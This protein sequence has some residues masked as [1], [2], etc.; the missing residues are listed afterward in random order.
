VAEKR[1]PHYDLEAIKAAFS[2]PS[3]LIATRSAIAG[4]AALGCGTDEIVSVIQSITREQ[5]YKS[6][7]SNYDNTVWQDVYHAVDPGGV[8]LYVKFT[9]NGG[10]DFLLLSFKEK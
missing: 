3:D 10:P 8:P 1:T 4:A 5:F 2:S 9:D 7:T 6:M